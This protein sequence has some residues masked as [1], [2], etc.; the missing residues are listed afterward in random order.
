MVLLFLCIHFFKN[1][2]FSIYEGK[3]KKF[4]K[5]HKSHPTNPWDGI[6]RDGRDFP[7]PDHM[8]QFA[9]LHIFIWSLGINSNWQSGCSDWVF[10]LKKKFTARWLQKCPRF[11]FLYEAQGVST[12]WQSF[13]KLTTVKN[14]PSLS[15]R[16]QKL[17][18]E[19]GSKMIQT[20]P[21]CFWQN[22]STFAFHAM[23]T[24][25]KP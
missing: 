25:I 10:C 18:F 12:L 7:N 16:W 21:S 6:C 9:R 8:D 23:V 5:S 11:K 20:C 14:M 1:K 3:S 13:R 15:I 2:I 17:N 22:F 24:G 4:H 19:V